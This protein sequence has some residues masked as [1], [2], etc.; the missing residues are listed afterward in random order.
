MI[1]PHDSRLDERIVA[2]LSGNVPAAVEERLRSQ[3]VDF[4]RRLAAPRPIAWERGGIWSRPQWWGLGI[5][6]AAVVAAFVGGLFLRSPASFADVTAAVF[7][8]PWIHVEI[9][10]LD[11]LAEAWYS[12]SKGITA[13]R[14]PDSIQYIDHQTLIEDS[15]R[16]R[17]QT[18]YRL[19]DSQRNPSGEIESLAT[20]MTVLLRQKEGSRDALQYV[21]FFRQDRERITLF[22]Q[23]IEQVTENG[24]TWL[25]DRI[26]FSDPKSTEPVRMLFR[27]DAATKLLDRCRLETQVQGKSVGWEMR[28]NYPEAG[29]A[30]VY[31]LG[32]PRSARLVDRVPA[33]D[34][35]RILQT[36][37]AGRV[38]MDNYRAVF[39]EYGDDQSEWW[40]NF[41]EILYRK[42]DRFRRDDVRPGT[43]MADV[44]PPARGEDPGKW[45]GN[46]VKQFRFHP[47]YVMRGVKNY[48]PEFKEV[49]DA[50]GTTHLEIVSVSTFDTNLPPG[51]TYPMDYSWRPEFICRPPLG[52]GA[53]D[54]E[55]SIDLHPADGPAGCL[56]LS[57]RHPSTRDRINAKGIELPDDWQFW[58]DPQRDNIVMR[59]VTVRRDGKGLERI[60][61]DQIVEETARSPQGVWYATKVRM[62][63]VMHDGKGKSHDQIRHIYVDFGAEL[64]DSLFDP[65]RPGRLD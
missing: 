53:P 64:P 6:V 25:D 52:I 48:S 15:Y 3:L 42:G 4:R 36:I 61:R 31:A 12:P 23:K 41:P 11:R 54:A 38:R 27:A 2:S 18:L 51:E 49:A 32:V 10:G 46:R 34:V 59:M 47:I 37:Q 19:P 43:P 65:P 16:P 21:P 22:E 33:G 35:K 7:A 20:V 14:S 30:D 9:T 17:E 63:D 29:P 39:V 28:F 57:V 58:V 60:I 13:W 45:W 1:A 8:K 62:K 5:A 24:H 26:V 44:T 40:R 50:D 55:P 56:L